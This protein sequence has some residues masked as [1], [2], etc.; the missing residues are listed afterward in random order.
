MQL[1]VNGLKGESAESDVVVEVLHGP[2]VFPPNVQQ[3]WEN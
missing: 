2:T 1:P 3:R